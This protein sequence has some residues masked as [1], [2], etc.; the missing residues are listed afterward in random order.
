[1]DNFGRLESEGHSTSLTEWSEMTNN[2]VF[3]PRNNYLPGFEVL[4][5]TEKV[6]LERNLDPTRGQN[7]T[8]V[9]EIKQLNLHYFHS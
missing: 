8:S 7:F 9:E 3:N 2:T 4:D 6:F 5:G 1:M